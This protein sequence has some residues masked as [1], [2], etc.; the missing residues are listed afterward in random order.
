MMIRKN[1]TTE[2][3]IV[4]GCI[5]AIIG[6]LWVFVWIT[7]LRSFDWTPMLYATFTA[8]VTTGFAACFFI[9]KW[10]LKFME[11]RSWQQGILFGSLFAILAG[12]ISGAM[13]GTVLKF[14]TSMNLLG[15]LTTILGG[16]AFGSLSGLVI[17]LP[18]SL[19][20]GAIHTT[21]AR[22]RV[23]LIAITAMLIILISVYIYSL[24]D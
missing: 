20:F 6:G 16:L 10:Y 14:Y 23:Y 19:I 2:A 9:S 13:T 12:A 7:R 4:V 1:S 17:G 22:M 18:S 21:S 15:P 24:L 11:H 8:G 5:G 3:S